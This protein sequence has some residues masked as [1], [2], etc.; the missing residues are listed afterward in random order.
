[1]D[2]GEERLWGRHIEKT[3][4][5]KNMGKGKSQKKKTSVCSLLLPIFRPR[6]L[7]LHSLPRHHLRRV[8][9]SDID[10][11]YSL[12]N[13]DR[14]DDTSREK[15]ALIGSRHGKQRE[16]IVAQQACLH[17]QLLLRDFDNDMSFPD[18]LHCLALPSRATFCR[19]WYTLWTMRVTGYSRRSCEMV[20]ESP[21]RYVSQYSLD[22]TQR[23]DSLHI[24]EDLAED[25]D[26]DLASAQSESNVA[27]L[28]FEP[29]SENLRKHLLHF[30]C[31]SSPGLQLHSAAPIPGNSR[32]P[33]PR[34][35]ILFGPR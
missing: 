20:R 7:S 10:G 26:K 2:L 28:D 16:D 8:L 11:S 12:W 1:V 35:G 31:L 6:Q 25:Q 21:R 15:S 17:S 9:I 29:I 14:N 23:Q 22:G 24:S 27:V 4:K 34:G 13:T 18:Y 32:S 19:A 5:S 30:R 33:H 3:R